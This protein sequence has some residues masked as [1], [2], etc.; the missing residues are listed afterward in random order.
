IVLKS[1]RKRPEQRY[2]SA[3]DLSDDIRR[4][5]E[6]VPVSARKATIP[7]RIGKLLRRN[8][9]AFSVAGVIVALLVGM[10]GTAWVQSLR[11][12]RE[13]DRAEQVSS[14]LVSLFEVSDPSENRGNSIRAREVLDRGAAKVSGELEGEPAVQ[15]ALMDTL[16]RVYFNMGL[17]D[18]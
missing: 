3:A 15:S 1:L 6:G 5:L 17:Y 11:T 4:H 12:A 8:R 10:A 13:R 9:A 2:A 14:F 7:Y 16:G 18:S